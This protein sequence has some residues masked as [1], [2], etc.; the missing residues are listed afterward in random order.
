MDDPIHQIENMS[1]D[2]KPV[3]EELI[4][5]RTEQERLRKLQ[6]M[7][8]SIMK[9][10]EIDKEKRMKSKK[11][12]EDYYSTKLKRFLTSSFL[13]N[14]AIEP[15]FLYELTYDYIVSYLDMSE[16]NLAFYPKTSLMIAFCFFKVIGLIIGHHIWPY[17]KEEVMDFLNSRRIWLRRLLQV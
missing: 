5:A 1:V 3:Q 7:R 16:N 6:N 15:F 10:E 17:I 8:V 12:K 9:Q 11:P 14:M 4:G 2:F 13:V